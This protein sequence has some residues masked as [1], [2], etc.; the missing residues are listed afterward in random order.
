MSAAIHYHEPLK[1]DRREREHLF[2]NWVSPLVSLRFALD[3]TSA[4]ALDS[5]WRESFAVPGLPV[6]LVL[7]ANEY[8][9]IAGWFRDALDG[10][11]LYDEC[12]HPTRL[13]AQVMSELSGLLPWLSSGLRSLARARVP[14]SAHQRLA[15]AHLGW[16]GLSG[17]I[18]GLDR[19]ACRLWVLAQILDS[20]CGTVRAWLDNYGAAKL[21]SLRA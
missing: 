10:P 4:L 13:D 14:S 15:T 11:Y 12:W 16:N 3:H 2:Y 9:A 19:G 8:G 18:A 17:A 21:S 6:E 1:F 5:E 20:S 7:E